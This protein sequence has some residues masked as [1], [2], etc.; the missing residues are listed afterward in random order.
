MRQNGTVQYVDN[1]SLGDGV[2]YTDQD[3]YTSVINTNQSAVW[4]APYYDSFAKISMVTA[5][6][7]IY[8][9]GKLMGEMERFTGFDP[10]RT[11]NL[12]PGAKAPATAHLF[13][14]TPSG[15]AK[16]IKVEFTNRF[17]EKFAQEINL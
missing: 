2:Y 5:S 17:G 7:P 3:W 8:Q 14:A 10:E 12:K 6:A 11:S 1:Y 9:D 16:V 13:R 4:S 15:S